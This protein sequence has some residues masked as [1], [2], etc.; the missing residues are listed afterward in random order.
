MGG[1]EGARGVAPARVLR[2]R[3]G[4]FGPFQTV[5]I[6]LPLVTPTGKRLPLGTLPTPGVGTV[7]GKNLATPGAPGAQNFIKMLVFGGFEGSRGA[8]GHHQSTR[9]EKIPWGSYFR[10]IWL[11]L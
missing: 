7:D 10:E 6:A 11:E 5:D 2:L 3:L 9:D 1:W 4:G 8:W